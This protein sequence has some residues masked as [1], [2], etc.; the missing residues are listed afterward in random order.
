[1]AVSMY[2]ISFKESF[3][4]KVLCTTTLESVDISKL[5]E[6]I[7]DLYYFEFVYGKT[8]FVVI[9]LCIEAVHLMALILLNITTHL[10]IL[11]R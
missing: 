2:N 7:E 10:L 6:A 8:I 4:R 11:F 9:S 3:E 1:M 5:Q